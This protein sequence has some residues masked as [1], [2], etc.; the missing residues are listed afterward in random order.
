MCLATP[1]S[2]FPAH[3]LGLIAPKSTWSRKIL[4][5]MLLVIS[6]FRLP[7]ILIKSYHFQIPIAYGPVERLGG[8]IQTY[9]YDPDGHLIE[10]TQFP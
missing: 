9:C 7:Q 1:A 4:P 2:T 3:G 5:H 10:F 6:H 8:L